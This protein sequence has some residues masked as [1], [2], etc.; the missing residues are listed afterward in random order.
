[1]LLN[2]DNGRVKEEVYYDIWA[3]VILTQ[4]TDVTGHTSCLEK[5]AYFL[6]LLTIWAEEI[7]QE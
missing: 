7:Q 4:E 3:D 2:I 1:M 6:S 5:N